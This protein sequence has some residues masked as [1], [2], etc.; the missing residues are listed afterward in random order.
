MIGHTCT[1]KPRS[2]CC[3][4]N[5]PSFAVCDSEELTSYKFNSKEEKQKTQQ[6]T[7]Y[8]KNDK[9]DNLLKEENSSAPVWYKG[10]YTYIGQLQQSYLLFENPQGLVLIDQHAAQERV[11]FEE[12]LNQIETSSVQKQPLMFP[13]NIPLAASKADAVLAWQSFLEQAG[14][15]IS[16]FSAGTLLVNSVPHLLKFKEEDI[17]DFIISFS[18]VIGNPAK[19]DRDF[20]YRLI[21]T[22]ACKKSVKAGEKL[23]KEQAQALLE[24]MKKCKDAL[25]CPHGRPTLITLEMKELSK[26]FGRS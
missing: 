25:H 4:K 1:R 8:P 10:P 7:V 11:Y 16:R 14:F 6:Q 21:S 22:M 15:E 12:Y 13:V 3:H 5:E 26:K 20:K 17:K 23:G 19:S 2:S 9:A 24:S 18:D